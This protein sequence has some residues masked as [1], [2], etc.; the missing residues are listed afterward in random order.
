ML[1]RLACI[2]F[3]CFFTCIML[4]FYVKPCNFRDDPV[5][6]THTTGKWAK[7][8]IL[9]WALATLLLAAWCKNII[10]FHFYLTTV[11]LK[12]LRQLYEWAQKKSKNLSTAEEQYLKNHVVEKQEKEIWQRHDI[13]PQ[14][15]NYLWWSI[16]WLSISLS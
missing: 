2:Y 12:F 5:C 9:N 4:L 1:A 7:K 14:R 15:Y 6:V 11:S 8:T 13:G 3:C 16:Y 10:Y